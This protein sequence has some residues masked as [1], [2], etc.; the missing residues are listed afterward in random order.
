M[1]SLAAR[2]LSGWRAVSLQQKSGVIHQALWYILILSSHHL[3][4]WSVH[5]ALS[6]EILGLQWDV[7]AGA[8]PRTWL[9]FTSSTERLVSRD[10]IISAS[11]MLFGTCVSDAR[12]LIPLLP[13][14]SLVLHQSQ[15]T[16]FA[17]K[18]GISPPYVLA[19]CKPSAGTW[20][21]HHKIVKEW[22][23]LEP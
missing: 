2:S 11:E 22:F 15:K 8:Q 19:A 16:D 1:H 13:F 4:D 5:G 10:Y 3:Q 20:Y 6:K 7:R 18:S 21:L 14:N 17:P 9:R 12:V 23:G